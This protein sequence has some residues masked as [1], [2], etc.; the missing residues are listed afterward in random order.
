MPSVDTSTSTISLPGSSPIDWG[1]IISTAIK[2]ATQVAQ[3]AFLPSGSVVSTRTPQ[4]STYV[5]TGG[6]GVPASLFGPSGPGGSS[7][8]S[9]LPVLLLGGVVL[10]ALASSAGGGR[11]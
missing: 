11:R 10:F 8:G 2:G 4:G 3:Y 9:L 7:L 6:A 5:S 1:N